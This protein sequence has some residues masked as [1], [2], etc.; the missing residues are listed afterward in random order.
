MCFSRNQPYRILKNP[1]SSMHADQRS[2]PTRSR[3]PSTE[4]E[5]ENTSADDDAPISTRPA[6]KQS[7]ARNRGLLEDSNDES[8]TSR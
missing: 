1:L 2:A 4:L 8:P 3:S 6:A 5:V 7:A